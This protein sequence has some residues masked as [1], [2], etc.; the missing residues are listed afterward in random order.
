MK[1]LIYIMTFSLF[2]LTA[3]T[4]FAECSC[5]GIE[6]EKRFM[7]RED[8]GAGYG[9]IDIMYTYKF[10]DC[11]GIKIIKEISAEWLGNNIKPVSFLGGWYKF[12]AQHIQANDP[13]TSHIMFPSTCYKISHSPGSES[14]VSNFS[15]LFCNNTCCTVPI[16][17]F[18][19]GTFATG[20][21]KNPECGDECSGLCD[22]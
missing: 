7:I 3:S 20:L 2:T 6:Y 19:N 21:D 11:G 10:E 16:Q 22:H 18:F 13:S 5:T 4:T 8:N 17:D 15:M 9:V 1:N 14:T 12:V